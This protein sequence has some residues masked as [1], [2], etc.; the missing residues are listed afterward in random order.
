MTKLVTA[1]ATSDYQSFIADGDDSFKKLKKKQFDSVASLI[2]PRL[3]ARY[4]T[5][6]FGDIQ[7]KGYDVTVW[8]LRFD[9]GGDDVLAILSIKDNKVG[10][11]W[12]K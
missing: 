5:T 12:V 4:T 10:G 6:Y 3:K 9:A 2:A 11:F 8:R 1:L 7:Q